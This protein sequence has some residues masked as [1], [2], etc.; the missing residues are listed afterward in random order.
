[1]NFYQNSF[2]LK[3]TRFTDENHLMF[4]SWI[5]D[6][7]LVEQGIDPDAHIDLYAQYAQREEQA[8]LRSI[9]RAIYQQMK[10]VVDPNFLNSYFQRTIKS[11]DEY[12]IF[13][14]QFTIYYSTNCYLTQL[15]QIKDPALNSNMKFSIKYGWVFQDHVSLKQW[16]SGQGDKE[17]TKSRSSKQ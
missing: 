14:K 2:Y 1:M 16:E 12:F 15:L 10:S 9:N 3:N 13:W 6:Q 5:Y 17:E 4:A 11:V 7:L 8:D